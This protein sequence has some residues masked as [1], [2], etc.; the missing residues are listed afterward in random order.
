MRSSFDYIIVGAGSAGCVLSARLSQRPDVSVLLLE[1]GP[2]DRSLWLR[3]PAGFYW[4]TT[5]QRFNWAYSSE[6]EAHLDGRRI[7]VPRGRV[8]GG[9]SSING[10]VWIRGNRGDYDGWAAE[11]ALGQWSYAHCLPYFRRSE[12]RDAGGDA[13]RGGDGP[14]GVASIGRGRHPLAATFLAAATEAG[15]P[16]GHDLSGERQ[17]GFGILEGSIAGGVRSSTARCYLAPAMRRANL[18]VRTGQRVLRVLFEQGRATGIEVAP[19]RTDAAAPVTR[20]RADRE[21]LLCAGA[22][23][24][25]KLLM[26][27]GIGPAEHLGAHGLPVL[28]DQPGVGAGLQDHLGCNVRFACKRPV[29]LLNRLRPLARLGIGTRWLWSRSGD[30]ATNHYETGGFVRTREEL[31]Y[32]DLQYHFFPAAVEYGKPAFDGIHGFQL[33]VTPGLPRSRGRL[34]LHSADA[35]DAP[36][37][38]FG[39]LGDPD[40]FR[41]FHEGI[42]RAREIVAQPAFDE[43]RGEEL[44]PGASLVTPA[45]IDPWLRATARSDYHPSCTCR[46]GGEDAVLDGELRVR[47]TSGLRV[48]DASVMPR[49]VNANLNATVVMI[50]EK[51]A[52]LITGVEPLPAATV[53]RG[54]ASRGG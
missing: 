29:S 12:A 27:S 10:L 51:A 1:A 17:D 38:A 18:E 28:V 46:M 8:L 39:Y 14:I 25:P 37:L 34:S 41:D 45:G 2:P 44:L 16:T 24:T 54:E 30:G 47:G 9:S 19:F 40:D 15:Y 32:P 35:R 42:R 11:P 49:I 36:R 31:P 43:F 53:Q 21:V 26:L 20:L 13:W 7:E 3:M 23:D 4:P 50:A 33:R 48:V 6:P 22:V 5:N 52:D